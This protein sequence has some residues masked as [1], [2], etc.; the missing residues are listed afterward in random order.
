M[1][2]VG[3][4]DKPI[5]CVC[6]CVCVP[7]LPR[8]WA[9]PGPPPPSPVDLE[10]CPGGLW[11]VGR[12]GFESLFLL[13]RKVQHLEHDFSALVRTCLMSLLLRLY[14]HSLLRHYR[15]P[16]VISCYESVSTTSN[17]CTASQ[18]TR[19]KK[20]GWSHP[21][22]CKDPTPA[23]GPTHHLKCLQQGAI[24]AISSSR[25]PAM[26]LSNP[27]PH[28]CLCARRFKLLTPTHD[29]EARPTSLKPSP[30]SSSECLLC[31]HRPR[32][33]PSPARKLQSIC[34]KGDHL[35]HTTM[36]SIH[37]PPHRDALSKK[38]GGGGIFVYP[39]PKPHRPHRIANTTQHTTTA[40]HD[41]DWSPPTV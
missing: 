22:P 7:G 2:T 24:P 15:V 28:F 18:N 41:L 11:V 37:A 31:P 16:V 4:E 36:W 9:G 40:H 38:G 34:A 8:V 30:T 33:R 39:V 12:P 3:R 32:L 26:S 6:V 19:Q 23:W 14:A 21:L 17:R 5:V 27:G 1:T 25:C 20:Q 29:S 35:E 13:S 10:A